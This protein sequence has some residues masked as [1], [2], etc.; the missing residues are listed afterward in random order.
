MKQVSAIT[1]DQQIQ[2]ISQAFGRFFRQT[3]ER[4][5]PHEF[6]A[7]LDP[8]EQSAQH[9]LQTALQDSTN[10]E[11]HFRQAAAAA[12]AT[13]REAKERRAVQS[14]VWVDLTDSPLPDD[15]P[16]TAQTV[17]KA[18]AKLQGHHRRAVSL[19]LAGMD[20][21]EIGALLH[22][23]KKKTR[24]QIEQGLQALRNQLR[25]AGIEYEIDD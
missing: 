11:F 25:A 6:G 20:A 9:K 4:I 19:Y 22:W 10:N 12:L 15:A 1:G 8:L 5:C 16:Q 18:L 2:P 3:I 14:V 24:Q 21:S 7:Q 17:Q 23:N 13:I